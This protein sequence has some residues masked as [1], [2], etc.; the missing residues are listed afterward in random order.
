MKMR[1]HSSALRFAVKSSTAETIGLAIIWVAVLA[2]GF[3]LGAAR[4]LPSLDGRYY[5]T[6]AMSRVGF[7]WPW[8]SDSIDF[9]HGVGDQLFP[10][11][12]EIIPFFRILSGLGFGDTAKVAGFLWLALELTAGVTFLAR[13]MGVALPAAIGASATMLVCI[14]PLWRFGAIYSF[15]HIAPQFSSAVAATAFA[16]GLYLRLG[17]GTRIADLA[18]S[19]GLVAILVWLLLATSTIAILSGPFLGLT[20]VIGLF[21]ASNNG[22]RWC[23]IAVLFGLLFMAACGPAWY[24]LS[25]VMSSAAF[26]FNVELQNSLAT[27][28]L[29][30]II[31][32]A[33][34]IGL[35]GP[36]L[37]AS[38]IGGAIVNWR[39][40]NRPLR[41][42]GYGMITYLTTRLTFAW[43]TI[44]FDFW[45]GPAPI[46]FELFAVP[47]YCIFAWLFWQ[48]MTSSLVAHWLPLKTLQRNVSVYASV[49][50]LCIA[51]AT[52][53]RGIADLYT[54]PPHQ[55]AITAYLSEHAAL[56]NEHPFAGRVATMTGL[57][58]GPSIDW[59]TL[60]AKSDP[61]AL[62][63]TGNDHRITGLRYFR[64]PVLFEYSPTVTA[65]FYAVTTRLLGDPRDKQV[66]NVQVLRRIEPR[67]LAMLGVRYII[68]DE[69][70]A[71]TR[72]SLQVTLSLGQ[73]GTLYLYEVAQPNLGNY[74]PVKVVGQVD[75]LETLERLADPDFN[76]ALQVV[77]DAQ[78]QP[79]N[80][81]QATNA[82]MDFEG[83][84]LHVS[85]DSNGQSLLVLPLQYSHCLIV[86]SESQKLP[87]LVRAN[88]VETGVVF[89]GRLDARI[90]LRTGPF[91]HP[92][93]RFDDSADDRRLGVGKIPRELGA[94]L[95]P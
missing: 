3:H 9:L 76:P 21:A 22:E 34:D 83:A 79:E 46:Y 24:V 69:P 89:E 20:G 19:I 35:M 66:R 88:L 7:D 75:A 16:A 2:L 23:K 73:E 74:S 15:V 87:R 31:F 71:N 68:T 55:S 42:F 61:L 32:H 13:S 58:L 18:Y 67:I 44:T 8:S 72:L 36:V 95:P 52:G 48:K 29:S 38:A 39:S 63:H 57:T 53:N 6:L 14:L 26:V 70:V 51:I 56:R 37:V 30:S 1:I 45:R 33:S 47:L 43:L 5:L 90:E 50:I 77:L 64:I 25:E 27:W 81:V 28:P 62:H 94:R 80:L 54:F 85:A 41:F 4:L 11:R 82:R 91:L 59:F 93:C 40:Q 10:F 12:P 78:P 60:I 92:L 86:D 65:P 84:R 49:A 17:R